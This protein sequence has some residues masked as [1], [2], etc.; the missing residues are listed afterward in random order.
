M[1]GPQYLS[2]QRDVWT[3]TRSQDAGVARAGEAAQDSDF[4]MGNARSN[5]S[6][7]AAGE[8][9]NSPLPVPHARILSLT[10]RGGVKLLVG[11]RA[12]PEP[13]HSNE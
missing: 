10:I 4:F 3:I 9:A 13:I 5:D 1:T 8:D 11:C 12:V 6:P 7:P 2:K